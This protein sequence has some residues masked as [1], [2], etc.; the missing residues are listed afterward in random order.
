MLKLQWAYTRLIY[1]LNITL[2][3]LN[4]KHVYIIGEVELQTYQDLLIN[5]SKS[6]IY[7]DRK[8]DVLLNPSMSRDRSHYDGRDACFFIL[9]TT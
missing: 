7:F 5:S 1:F 3:S 8:E 4:R 9:E 2:G 6:D